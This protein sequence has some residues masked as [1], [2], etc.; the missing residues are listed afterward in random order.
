M[1]V[2]CMAEFGALYLHRIQLRRKVL[3][4]S[5][6]KRWPFLNEY[7]IYWERREEFP[8]VDPKP[9]RHMSVDELSWPIHRKHIFTSCKLVGHGRIFIISSRGQHE[10]IG[11]I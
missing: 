4:L 7:V 1:L 11:A 2:H 6:S 9:W 10:C 5:S 8:S 3:G